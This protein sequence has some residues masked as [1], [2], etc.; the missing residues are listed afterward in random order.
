MLI[1]ATVLL[2]LVALVYVFSL[3][4]VGDDFHPWLPVGRFFDHFVTLSLRT[5]AEHFMG[6]PQSF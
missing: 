2:W 5:M 4:D 3:S 1:T 6:A